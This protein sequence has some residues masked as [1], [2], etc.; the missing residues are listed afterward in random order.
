MPQSKSELIKRRE[1]LKDREAKVDKVVSA[2]ET[3][4]DHLER[5]LKLEREE[6][7][8][9]EKRRKELG[10]A[11]AEEI[12]AD[13]SGEG[14]KSEHWEEWVVDR[15]D[16]LADMIDASE[17]RINRL[18]EK[19]IKT[20]KD[21]REAKTR[22]GRLEQQIQIVQ[23]RIDRKNTPS[24]DLTKD[25]SMAEFDCNDGT[26]VP[27]YMRGSLKKLCTDHLQPLRDAG[28]SVHINSG[29]R[30]VSYNAR[31]GGEPNSYHIYT[32]RKDH[33]AADHVQSGRAPS[34]VASFHES[35]QTVPIGLGRYSSF[36]HLDQRGYTSRWSG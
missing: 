19:M 21:L 11:L 5:E 9:L 23:K 7:D 16:E 28:G 26:P 27:E 15:R 32:Y 31:I 30:T 36:T 22:D 2:K 10:E 34:S 18:V 33:P 4:L 25:F 3:K 12:K 13:Q 17:G 35:H 24:N 29:Y 14:E 6:R 1:A 20:G 8:E